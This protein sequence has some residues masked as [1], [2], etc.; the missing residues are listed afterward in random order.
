MRSSRVSA[1]TPTSGRENAQSVLRVKSCTGPA[2]PASCSARGCSIFADANRSA[3]SPRSSRSRKVPDGPKVNSISTPCVRLSAS[4]TPVSGAM[5]LPAAKTLTGAW[6]DCPVNASVAKSTN[7]STAGNTLDRFICVIADAERHVVENPVHYMVA[8][9]VEP[10][11][12][13]ENPF[14]ALHE[15]PR[16]E[17]ARAMFS[18]QARSRQR[19]LRMKLHSH[20]TRAKRERL[21]T[22]A[23]AL[24]EMLRPMRQ[25]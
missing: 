17:I 20:H 16:L 24:G 14:F 4:A 7:A 8:T 22:A 23:D 6:L 12:S 13:G 1:L 11:I 3:D 2:F 15:G 5:R 21:M 19:H 9:C 25:I 10:R 18:E